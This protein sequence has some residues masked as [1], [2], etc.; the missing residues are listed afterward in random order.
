M[1]TSVQQHADILILKNAFNDYRKAIH[2]DEN[3]RVANWMKYLCKKR[4]PFEINLI[5]KEWIV[6]IIFFCGYSSILI[7]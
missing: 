5:K 1:I 3:C 2:E 4:N 6:N 7:I